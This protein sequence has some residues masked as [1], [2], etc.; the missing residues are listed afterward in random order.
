M[1]KAVAKSV[2]IAELLRPL[3]CVMAGFAAMLGYWLSA[4]AIAFVPQAL[5]AAVATFLICGAGQAINDYY[6]LAAD[7]KAK[8]HRPIPSGRLTAFEARSVAVSLFILGI[9]VAYYVNTGA[10]GVAIAFSALLFVYSSKLSGLKYFGNSVV[11]L[12]TAFTFVMGASVTGNYSFVAILAAASFFSTWAREIAK[13]LEDFESDKGRK[14][15]LPMLIG[16]KGAVNAAIISTAASSVVGMLPV[17]FGI[18][19][20]VLFIALLTASIAV[21]LLA[22]MQLRRAF[23]KSSQ[24]SYRYGMLVALAAFASLLF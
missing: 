21:F 23:Y 13:D 7:L 10:F 11:A 19:T 3:D 22:V 18:A 8:K 1:E 20:S 17:L 4:G 14:H 6:D 15:T 2:A 24:K 12:S 9:V 16:K 5:L